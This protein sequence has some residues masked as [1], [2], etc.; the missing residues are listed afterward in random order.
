M[1]CYIHYY[2]GIE[3]KQSAR[4]ISLSQVAYSMKLLE[5]CSSAR[6]NT[7]QT[8]ME[9]RLKLS[10]QSTYALVDATAYQSIVGSLRYL[11]NTCP[12]LA[13]AVG[14]V[15]LFLEELREDHLEV[16]KQILRYVVG[17]SNWGLWF[18][19]KKRN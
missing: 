17:T 8:P 7:C 10:K 19:R 2:L 12:G 15:S 13:F 18:S 11:V 6:C 9:A 16:L 14:Y 1:S 3:V 5:R 4:G